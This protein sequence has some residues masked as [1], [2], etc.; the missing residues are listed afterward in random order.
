LGSLFL[1][2]VLPT[3]LLFG[4]EATGRFITCVDRNHRWFLAIPQ[5]RRAWPGNR[6]HHAHTLPVWWTSEHADAV[7]ID[8]ASMRGES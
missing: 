4:P 2:G 7:G 1:P 3:E 8:W 6:W 5:R